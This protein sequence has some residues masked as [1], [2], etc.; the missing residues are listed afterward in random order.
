M[1]KYI[2]AEI[3]VLKYTLQIEHVVLLHTDGRRVIAIEHKDF[4]TV[5]DYFEVQEFTLNSVVKTDS[6]YIISF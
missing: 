3:E 2:S 4:K 1:G 5:M 6:Q